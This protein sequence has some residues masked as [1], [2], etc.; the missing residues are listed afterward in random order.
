M[1]KLLVPTSPRTSVLAKKTWVADEFAG[2]SEKLA[3]KCPIPAGKVV[4][5]VGKRANQIGLSFDLSR[6]LLQCK[7]QRG[8]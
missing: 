7:L 5:S 2:K 3:G 6:N 1:E 8:E 4:N